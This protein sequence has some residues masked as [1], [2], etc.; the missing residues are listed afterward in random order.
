MRISAG[1]QKLEFIV[2]GTLDDLVLHAHVETGEV[3]GEAGYADHEVLVVLRVLL[4]VAQRIGTD[5][6]ELNVTAAQIEVGLD[7]VEQHA[8][9]VRAFHSGG[10]E[11]H[12]QVVTVVANGVDSLGGGLDESRA[13]VC[14]GTGHGG[15]GGVRQGDALA[16]TVRQGAGEGSEVVVERQGERVHVGLIAEEVRAVRTIGLFHV[17]E[18][19]ADKLIDIVNV[20]AVLG[21]FVAHLF[22]GFVAVEVGSKGFLQLGHGEPLGVVH[23]ML[24]GVQRVGAV[25]AGA[26]DA[27]GLAV[28]RAAR[29]FAE[30]GFDAA[31]K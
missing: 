24:D 6:V 19:A 9:A 4:R 16:A 29:F 14:I 2:L 30:A 13:A 20:V 23:K 15:H 11:L 22:D 28:L 18:E 25:H 7:Q 10:Q 26:G 5:N 12:V 21:R 3:G 27:Q 17:A 1:C 8:G 31:V